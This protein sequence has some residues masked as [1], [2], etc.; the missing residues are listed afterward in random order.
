MIG[1]LSAA[2]CICIVHFTALGLALAPAH[3]EC[4]VLLG[5]LLLQAIT[6]DKGADS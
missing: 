5:L 6:I 2:L 4:A 1:I 3:W